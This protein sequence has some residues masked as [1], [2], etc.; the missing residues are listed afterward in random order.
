MGIYE[1]FDFYKPQ[2]CTHRIVGCIVAVTSAKAAFLVSDTSIHLL[3]FNIQSLL[4]SIVE[5]VS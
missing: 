1:L 4:H 2:S 5:V 3:F